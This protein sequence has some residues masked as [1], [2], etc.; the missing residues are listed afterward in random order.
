MGSAPTLLATSHRQRRREASCFAKTRF[1]SEQ[2]HTHSSM[3]LPGF[4]DAGRYYARRVSACVL[5][6]LVHVTATIV[7]LRTQASKQ[8]WLYSMHGVDTSTRLFTA[9]PPIG[10]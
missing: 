6:R 8:V 10:A 4:F 3:G 5:G 1:P 2:A 9:A 7:E